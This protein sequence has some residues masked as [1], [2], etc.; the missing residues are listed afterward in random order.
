MIEELEAFRRGAQ[1]ARSATA[2]LAN[3]AALGARPTD[4]A[5]AAGSAD[6]APRRSD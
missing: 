4:A 5:G 6:C 2:G 1:A 3:E